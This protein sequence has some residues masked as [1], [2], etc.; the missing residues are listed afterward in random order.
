MGAALD[1]ERAPPAG[2]GRPL[3]ADPVVAREHQGERRP[4]VL[5]LSAARRRRPAHERREGPDGGEGACAVARRRPPPRGS[6]EDRSRS[7]ARVRGTLASR[8]SSGRRWC[9]CMAAFRKGAGRRGEG[10][11]C[12]RRAHPRAASPPASRACGRPRRASSREA[13]RESLALSAGGARDDGGGRGGPRRRAAVS[14]EPARARP[15]RRAGRLDRRR[16]AVCMERG[17]GRRE[18]GVFRHGLRGE[19]WGE[20]CEFCAAAGATTYARLEAQSNASI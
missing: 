8:A 14:M 6:P 2:G 19:A 1:G 10:D 12:A 7:A 5:L 20:R 13:R 3:D 4:R 16:Q 15:A 9:G 17:G 11:R 18:G